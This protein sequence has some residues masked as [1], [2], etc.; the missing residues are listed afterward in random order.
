M[1]R[2]PQSYA[3][4]KPSAV[5]GGSPAQMAYFVEDACKDIATLAS[6]VGKLATL[7]ADAGEIGAGML[8]QLVTDA[9][10]ALTVK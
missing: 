3:S 5:S 2:S 8:K 9:R 1:I 4:C 10:K 6:V 7:N